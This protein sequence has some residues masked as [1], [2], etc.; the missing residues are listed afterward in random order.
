MRTP[1]M[2]LDCI[3]GGPL[4]GRDCAERGSEGDVAR[5]LPLLAEAAVRLTVHVDTF[6]CAAPRCWVELRIDPKAGTWRRL[7]DRGLDLPESSTLEM[8]GHSSLVCA[9]GEVYCIPEDL[10]EAVR[11]AQQ[12]D[13]RRSMVRQ[14]VSA[15]RRGPLAHPCGGDDDAEPAREAMADPV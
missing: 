9:P 3:R 4:A 8:R 7:A 1:R 12:H 10:A 5:A 13:G 2:R 15:A 11:G 14:R 6:N